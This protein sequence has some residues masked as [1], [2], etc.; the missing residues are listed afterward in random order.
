[1]TQAHSFARAP[2]HRVLVCALAAVGACVATAAQAGD[3]LAISG[4]PPKSIS[5]GQSLSFTPTVSD[6]S[7][8]SL[9]FGIS[10]LPKW[11]TFDT[12]NGRISGTPTAADVGTYSDIFIAV[13]DWVTYITSPEYSIKVTAAAG[14]TDKPVIS[15]TP[16]SSVIVGN[17]YKF[18]PTAKDP[19]GKTLSF[20]VTN[21]PDWASFSISSGL[22]DG[23]PTSTETGSYGDI[24]ITAS[25]GTAS[26][27]LPAFSVAV[28]KATTPPPSTGS[29]TVDW[30]P[31]TKNTNGTPLTDL[32]GVRIYYGTSKT[33]LSSM[34]QVA[35]STETSTTIS[36]LSAG[37][38]YFSAAAY[39]TTGVQGAMSSVVSATI[40]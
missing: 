25:N 40:P 2:L 16:A 34:V 37:P 29:A 32:A 18:Q 3:G 20:S 21:K 19:D 13:T 33:A 36:K 5:V 27:A 17:T 26:S 10:G 31:P 30:V 6:P 8:R 24:I 23:T 39:T 12:A 15:G 4:A 1:M 14:T 35:S 9:K 38:W 11:A 7:K 28:T 22:L